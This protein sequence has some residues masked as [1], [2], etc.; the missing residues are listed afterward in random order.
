MSINPI[1]IYSSSIG[2]YNLMSSRFSST[3]AGLSNALSAFYTPS[4]NFTSAYS[5]AQTF[6]EGLQNASSFYSV[7]SSVTGAIK[8]ATSEMKSLAIQA[9]DPFL[10]DEDRAILDQEFQGLKEQVNYFEDFKFNGVDVYGSDISVNADA[11]SSLDFDATSFS[12]LQVDAN[13]SIDS[14]SNATL[15]SDSIDDTLENIDSSLVDAGSNISNINSAV[16]TNISSAIHIAEAE[17]AALA[18]SLPNL[19]NTLSEYQLLSNV[20][21]SVYNYSQNS[22]KGAISAILGF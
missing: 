17:S 9:Q 18:N 22:S 15:A 3:S 19:L 8:E 21:S 1:S 14:L 20:Q 2:N 16:D 6:N 13:A 4:S 12:D 5:S 11:Y 10:N 7:Q